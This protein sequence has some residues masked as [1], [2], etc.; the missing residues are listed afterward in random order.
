L[1]G[2]SIAAQSAGFSG[3][4]TVCTRVAEQFVPMCADGRISAEAARLFSAWTHNADRYLRKPSSRTLI[5]TLV[6]Q[7]GGNEWAQPLPA[8]DQDRYIQE[9]LAPYA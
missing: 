5:A 3:F 6:S 1:R 2:L 9:M 7:L 8:R 4:A